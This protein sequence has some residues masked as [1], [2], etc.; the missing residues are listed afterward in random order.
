MATTKFTNDFFGL[1]AGQAWTGTQNF[2]SATLTSTTPSSASADTTVATTSYVDTSYLRKADASSTY[3]LIAGQTWTGTHAFSTITAPGITSATPGST[4]GLYTTQTT[5]GNI[6]IGSSDVTTTV[7]GTLAVG[8]STSITSSAF[9]TS[10]NDYL[11]NGTGNIKFNTSPSVPVPTLGPHATTKEYVD[12][13]VGNYGGNGLSLYF[14][15]PSP[16]TSPSTGTLSN[17]LNSS[18]QVVV[19]DTIVSGDNLI[20]TFTTSGYPNTSL[21]PIGLW[22]ST[23]YGSSTSATGTLQYFFKLYKVVSG[24]PVLIGTSGYSYDINSITTNP[25]NF[26]CTYALTT[27]QTINTADLIQVEIYCLASAT[28]PVNTVLSTYFQGSTYSFITTSLNGGVSLLTTINSWTG[29]NTFMNGISTYTIRG[30]TAGTSVSLFDTTTGS[31]NLAAASPEVNIGNFRFTANSLNRQ[32]L[33]GNDIN[34]GDG[35]TTIGALLNLGTYAGRL[36]PIVI[37]AN[38]CAVN[39]GGILNANQGIVLGGTSFITTA[40]GAALP[41]DTQIG[42]E[43]TG[44]QITSVTLT[45]NNWWSVGQ[46]VLAPGVW[47]I[48]GVVGFSALQGTTEFIT[49][50]GTS[51]RA[52]G[53]GGTGAFDINMISNFVNTNTLQYLSVSGVYRTTASPTVYITVRAV[54]AATTPTVSTTNFSLKAYKLA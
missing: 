27:E 19:T 24:S 26:Y 18:A 38:S 13:V 45:N 30:Q 7:N 4:V 54:F 49:G 42:G 20:A 9:T 28:V 14:N 36:G 5:G 2:T 21:I 52:G 47:I 15:T 10:T 41:S 6:T 39:V 3:G 35:Q 50:L 8:Q 31:V 48:Y 34:I 51:N 53:T 43:K 11:F 40:G 22:T 44:T 46:I 32:V 16:T 37:G 29:T 23:I 33:A 25:G 12:T 17:L 1:K